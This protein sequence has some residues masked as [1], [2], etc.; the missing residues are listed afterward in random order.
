MQLQ[1]QIGAR[2][3]FNIAYVGTHGDRLSTYYPYNQYNFGTTS[4]P[5]PN[6]G[7]VTL[8][9]YQGISWYNG[10]QA[11]YEHRQGNAL[12]TASYT[13]SHSL[14]DSPDAFGGGSI[15]SSALNPFL[16]YGNSSQDQRHIFAGSAVYN[17][18]FGKGQTFGGGS[19]YAEEL[20]IGGWQLN[21]IGLFQSGQPVDLSTGVNSPGNR[22]DLVG[23]IRYPKQIV[24]Q[25]F[26]PTSFSDAIPLQS[27]S[28]TGVY[29]RVGTLG[30]NQIYGPG[31]R[32]INFGV[33][34]NVHLSE[35]FTLE[36]H[37]DAFNALNTPQ[38][39]NPSAS[40]TGS[41]F[42][43]ITGTRQQSNRQIQ[44]ASRLTF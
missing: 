19:N 42:G 21:L 10:L 30:R 35:R 44:L 2:D 16:E 9:A 39:T 23:A 38:F 15:V 27:V 17:L 1:Q 18:P 36:L 13:W 28:G 29:E 34:K 3:V 43:E 11:H 25:W 26:D 24:G 22:P 20:L 40:V 33:Q 31:Y 6:L 37:G 14:D 5:F 8:N 41:N 32:N 12:L 7:G 4:L